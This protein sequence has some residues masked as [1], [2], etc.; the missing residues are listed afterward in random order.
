MKNVAIL[1]TIATRNP[2]ITSAWRHFVLWWFG[3]PKSGPLCQCNSHHQFCSCPSWCYC[4]SCLEISFCVS[5]CLDSSTERLHKGHMGSAGWKNYKIWL[6]RS[7][8]VPQRYTTCSGVALVTSV[9]NMWS[10][11]PYRVPGGQPESISD[12]RFSRRILRW[13][14]WYATGLISLLGQSNNFL[15]LTGVYT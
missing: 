12:F 14:I 3:N 1:V 2:K 6:W 8:T 13:I 9:V 7:Q 10:M 11:F 15:R 4:A 5:L